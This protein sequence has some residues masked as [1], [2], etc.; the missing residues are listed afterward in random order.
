MFFV[1][2]A[3]LSALLIMLINIFK[4]LLRCLKIIDT[5]DRLVTSWS[6]VASLPPDI[7]GTAVKAVILDSSSLIY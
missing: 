7:F 3:R 2:Y 5:L 1:F 6:D 4:S